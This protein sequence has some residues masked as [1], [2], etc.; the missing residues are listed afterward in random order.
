LVWW[1]ESLEDGV[2]SVSIRN[3]EGN[4]FG[5][6]IGMELHVGVARPGE[7]TY[8]WP[9]DEPLIAELPEGA[10]IVGPGSRTQTASE[11]SAA[12]TTE[13]W[14]P[15]GGVIVLAIVGMAMLLAGGRSRLRVRSGAVPGTEA[16]RR[17]QR[18]GAFDQAPRR[19]DMAG[20]RRVGREQ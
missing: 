16:A 10:V 4:F 9:L 12:P 20:V 3:E 7:L 17:L 14:G 2:Y 19:D 1:R 15:P 18:A 13:Q 11:R 8:E 6:L 5:D